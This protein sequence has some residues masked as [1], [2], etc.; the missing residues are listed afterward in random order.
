MFV[1]ILLCDDG[2]TYVG[3]TVNLERRIRQHNKESTIHS[4]GTSEAIDRLE[5]G[6]NAVKHQRDKAKSY[7]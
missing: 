6:D 4:K 3:A 2:S 7:E 1:Y 5:S